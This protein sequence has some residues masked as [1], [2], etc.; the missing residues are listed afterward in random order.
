PE[1]VTAQIDA[2]FGDLAVDAV[3]IG[4]VSRRETIEAIVGGLQHWRAK[5]IVVDPVMIATSGDLLLSPSALEALRDTLIP[6]AQVVTPNLPEAAA[7]LGEPM[8]RTENGIIG[9][10][11][12]LLRLGC[13]VV[14]IKGGHGEGPDAID[15][16]FSADG[17]VPLA[18]PRIATAN[19]H[20]TGCSL[21][22]AI[23][24]GL[25]KGEALEIAVRH[26]KD[27]I[28][29]AIVAA[30]RLDVGHGHGPIHHFYALD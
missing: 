28:S 9:Q 30:G 7:L 22:S 2:V 8:A 4:M 18:A 15:Y 23:A 16:L 26:A 10:G 21:S 5:N 14:L 29:A 17:I 25:A 20:G 13:P 3:K 6:L 27:F 19:T 12:R 24:A 1:F 11:E